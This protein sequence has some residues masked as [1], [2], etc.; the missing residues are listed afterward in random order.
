MGSDYRGFQD[1][2]MADVSQA[3]MTA[4]T[5]EK[6]GRGNSKVRIRASE[7][8]PLI[9][10]GSAIEYTAT[11]GHKLKFGDIIFVRTGKDLSLRRF[12]AFEVGKGGARVVCVRVSPPTMEQHPDT[13]IVGKVVRVD[14]GGQSYDP[15]KKESL[16]QR[17]ANEWTYFGTCTPLQRI[18]RS[19]RA[20]GKL[21][22]KR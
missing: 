16:G 8:E 21:M 17:W 12:I 7:M 2:V 11:A 10:N 14:A 13:S 22:K 19:F 20:F 4:A 18:Q 9:P 6:S 15:Y 3:S 1:K 5:M